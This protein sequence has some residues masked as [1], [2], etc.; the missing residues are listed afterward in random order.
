VNADLFGQLKL[1]EGAFVTG[2]VDFYHFSGDN[3]AAD[4]VFAVMGAYASPVIGIG[5]IQPMLRFQF[6]NGEE[7]RTAM[8]VDAQLG[9]LIRQQRLR[10]IANFQ[11]TELKNYVT[12]AA[13]LSANRLQVAVQAQL[14]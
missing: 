6:A 10:I 1:A 13:D 8:A 2:E 7:D 9:Y 14:F 4:N 3:R 5:Q 12:G 11:H